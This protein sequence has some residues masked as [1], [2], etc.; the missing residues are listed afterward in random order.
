[1]AVFM[2]AGLLFPPQSL[3]KAQAEV[4][5]APAEAGAPAETIEEPAAPVE[6]PAEQTVEAP[7]VEPAVVELPGEQTVEAPPEPAPTEEFPVEQTVEVQ[8]VIPPEQAAE[9]AVDV[10]SEGDT[11][12]AETMQEIVA[13][14]DETNTIL[15][16]EN[17]EEIPLASAEAADALKGADPFFF[18]PQTGVFVGY[19]SGASCPSFVSECHTGEGTPFTSA[20]NDARLSEYATLYVEAATYNEPN[21]VVNR[22]INLQGGTGWF[23]TGS[24]ASLTVGYTNAVATIGQLT[25]RSNIGFL[26]NVVANSVF[27]DGSAAASDSERGNLLEDA[28]WIINTDGTITISDGTYQNET[29]GFL[30]EKNG[31]T[32]QGQ[33][34]GAVINGSNTG[35]GIYI[36]DYRDGTVLQNVSVRRIKVIDSGVAIQVGES[37]NSSFDHL[38]LTGNGTGLWA[39]PYATAVQIHNSIILG[40]TNWGIYN[41]GSS[42]L[43]ATGNYWGH[44]LGPTFCW[45]ESGATTCEAPK[46]G[47]YVYSIDGTNRTVSTADFLPHVA[48]PPGFFDSNSDGVCDATVCGAGTFDANSDGTCEATVCAPGSFDANSDGNCEATVCGAGTFDANSDGNCEAT[49][50]AAGTFDAN[51]DGYASP[52]SAHPAHLMPI[53]MAPAKPPFARR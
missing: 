6:L 40:N 20:L 8:Q 39:S 14:M 46:K 7:V 48:C 22:D 50:C 16:D 49:A 4:P 2:I 30:I 13:V 21:I 37:N 29:Y 35:Y 36:D 51:S 15:V 53:A 11:A 32:L 26:D 19:T 25:L 43:D 33:G 24:G 10:E 27:V 31:V 44:I 23:T 42:I 52:R 5:P 12:P 41:A 18:D 38:T 17:N 28:M 45:D 34:D 9:A 3:A 47:D 1:M